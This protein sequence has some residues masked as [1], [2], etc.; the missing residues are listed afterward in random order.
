MKNEKIL[1][2]YG[3][4]GRA[5]HQLISELILSYFNNPILSELDDSAVLETPGQKL[6]FSTDS[7]TVAP[8]FFLGSDIGELAI[9]GT[10]DDLAMRGAIPKYL[11]VG[12]II[13]EG[14]PFSDFKRILASM[15]TVAEYTGIQIVTGD[16][17]VVP[18][19]AADK[20]FI[21]TSGIGFIPKNVSISG[22]KAG[23]GDKIIISGTIGDHGITVF[24]QRESL[25]FDSELRYE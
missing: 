21:N 25:Q 11:S 20:I 12:F 14:F 18:R 7:D 8:L 17:K 13:E 15:K 16:T 5:S 22:K 6:A 3:S 2:D 4:G 10:V 23:P 24:M 19:K 1:P 9:N